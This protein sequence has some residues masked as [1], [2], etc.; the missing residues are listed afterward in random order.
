MT[1][2]ALAKIEVTVLKKTKEALV[3]HSSDSKLSIGE[4]ID[5]MTLDFAVNDPGLA[6]NILCENF[7][8]MVANQTEEQV[9]E[10]IKNIVELLIIPLFMKQIDENRFFDELSQGIH[11]RIYN[12]LEH[13]EKE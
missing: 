13:M 6:A 5:R 12:M 1:N 7:L 2:G 3:K 8:L 9:N 11:Q 4:V 10:T